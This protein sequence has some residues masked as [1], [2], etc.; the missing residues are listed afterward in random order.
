MK[1]SMFIGRWQPWHDG[2][3]WLI[4]QRLS[5]GKNVLIC[6]REVSKDDKNPYNPIEVKANVEKELK[7]LIAE[8]RVKVLIIPDIE[9]INYGRGVGYEI[10]EH[11]PPKNIGEISA[12]KIR[13][14]IFKK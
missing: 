14:E 7:D 5:E 6:V 1:Y 2:H 12:T 10:I 8:N 3:R 4:N 11:V 9:S 13:K